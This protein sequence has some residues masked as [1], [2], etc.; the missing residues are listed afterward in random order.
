MIG[1]KAAAGSRIEDVWSTC[2]RKLCV[3]CQRLEVVTA[4]LFV[5][6]VHKHKRL[7]SFDIMAAVLANIAGQQ[8]DAEAEGGGSGGSGGGGGNGAVAAVIADRSRVP[9]FVLLFTVIIGSSFVGE[10]FPAQVA[11]VIRKHTWAKHLA[12]LALLVV[13][14]V[15]IRADMSLPVL[16]GYTAITYAWYLALT[17]MAASQFL[18]VIALLFVVFAAAH[19]RAPPAPAALGSS[20]PTPPT[21]TPTPTA[22]TQE[23]AQ[24][25]TTQDVF[26]RTTAQEEG[27][28][29]SQT[30]KDNQTHPAKRGVM[31][32]W[33]YWLEFGALT[34]AASLTV[35]F[36]STHLL[37]ALMHDH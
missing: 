13:T 5:T 30:G 2:T 24:P 16:L 29:N 1:G 35:L 26:V 31:P 25:Q 9:D 6:T 33:R 37:G 10:L 28:T 3:L 22:P 27:A 8:R 19:L 36:S 34:A 14:V 17:N 4:A 23:H 12:A 18:I 7:S 21:T 11:D 20:L 32:A 15:W